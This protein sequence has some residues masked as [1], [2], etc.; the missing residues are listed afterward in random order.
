MSFG[1]G[2]TEVIEISRQGTQEPGLAG[3]DD[4][5]Q[6]VTAAALEAINKLMHVGLGPGEAALW[7][8][9]FG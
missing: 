9:V 2:E 4:Q 8:R 3:K 1:Q 5:T 6:A 7:R